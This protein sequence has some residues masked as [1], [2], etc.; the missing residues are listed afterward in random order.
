MEGE[1]NRLSLI[2][3]DGDVFLELNW[4]EIRILY[5]LSEW[6]GN[7]VDEK[8]ANV[9]PERAL[10]R[11]FMEHPSPGASFEDG[12]DHLAELGLVSRR[13][14]GRVQMTPAG[15]ILLAR[16]QKDGFLAAYFEAFPL[17]LG[18]ETVPDVESPAWTEAVVE[19]IE[20]VQPFQEALAKAE[21]LPLDKDSIAR[22]KLWQ[23]Y[24]EAIE[25][26]KKEMEQLA[27]AAEDFPPWLLREI[28]EDLDQC[29]Y[30]IHRL[31]PKVKALVAGTPGLRQ[32]IL[33]EET[34]ATD[35]TTDPTEGQ[36]AQPGVA[37]IGE[38]KKEEPAGDPAASVKTKN[39]T[40]EAKSLPAL[41]PADKDR[42]D[43]FME[44]M[45]GLLNDVEAGRVDVSEIAASLRGVPQRNSE[46]FGLLAP[47]V[48][49][50]KKGKRWKSDSLRSKMNQLLGS[51]WP[52]SKPFKIENWYTLRD[53]W[54]AGE[55]R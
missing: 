29:K 32:I 10:H 38:G 34:E 35:T 8:V 46:L 40:P 16:L 18:E 19:Y 12:A 21:E 23:Q 11:L 26:W 37:N 6:K 22:F 3:R 2:A 47:R 15:R 17:G 25:P 30:E 14:P 33:P 4:H 51:Y 24:K 1:E 55:I 48:P 44:A 20:K 49:L 39:E 41:S 54:R 27:A 43:T 9:V 36:G 13:L 52:W 42:L 31:L 28:Q 53:E 45:C 5:V 50:T 7:V